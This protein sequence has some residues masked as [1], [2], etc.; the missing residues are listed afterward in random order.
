MDP[1]LPS[2]LSRN[3][4]PMCYLIYGTLILTFAVF[5]HAMIEPYGLAVASGDGQWSVIALGWEMVP[6]IWPLF[7]FAAAI[8][9]A[10]T[11]LVMRPGGK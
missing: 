6:E 7:L 3:S 5:S 1:A 11:Y 10:L 4:T 2:S 9:S 8:G